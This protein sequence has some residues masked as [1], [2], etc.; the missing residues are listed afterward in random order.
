MVVALANFL[1]AAP[2]V[3]V[4]VREGR[5]V[6][7][8][9][10][11]P[12][13]DKYMLVI[14]ALTP[15]LGPHAVAVRTQAVR[16]EPSVPE[17]AEA[18]SAAWLAEAREQRRRIE[19]AR[20]GGELADEF[21]TSASPP[22]ERVFHLFIKDQEFT[23]PAAYV[24]V[25]GELAA[26]GKHVQVY[27]DREHPDPAALRPTVDDLIRTFDETVYPRARRGLGRVL[28]VDRDGRFTVLLTDRLG[29]LVNGRVSIS[30]FVRGS[31]F[32]RDMPA[33]FS[34]HCDMMYL[35]ADLKPGP[36]L[37]TVLAH[38]YTHAVIFSE[39]VFGRG[40]LGL[41]PRDEETWLNEAL[42]HVVEKERGFGWTNLDYR[43]SAFLNAPERYGVVIED[44][45]GAGLWRSHGHRGATF[46][47]LDACVA[48][49]SLPLVARLVQSPLCGVRNLEVAAE[50]PFP[51]LFRDWT[52]RLAFAAT[53]E[54]C[55]TQGERWLCGPHFHIMTMRGANERLTLAGTSAAFVLLHSPTAEATRVTVQAAADVGLQVTLLHL[56]PHSARLEL[57]TDESAGKVRLT[58][59]AHDADVRLA[60]AAWERL[61]PVANQPGDTSAHSEREAAQCCRTWFGE[62]LLKAGETRTSA[63]IERP[64]CMK[65]EAWLFKVSGVD[66]TGACIRAW[67]VVGE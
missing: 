14:G 56:P 28:D 46:L 16:E 5:C 31:D 55:G 23:D 41:A 58:L 49:A 12:A 27:V 13:G 48:N 53:R 21:P 9:P 35:N 60:G 43:V 25:T 3:P 42:A 40:S 2:P 52:S 64:D 65:K 17:E 1:T 20:A 44:Y 7:T 4:A 36:H 6:F 61:V 11:G 54:P 32:Y 24:A 63:T 47:F 50:R 57:T 62:E 15:K 66:T 26:L 37:R 18:I 29:R 34:N 51:L 59:R 39:H 45:Y 10:A 67:A 38:E 30:G 33:P 19:A 8:L 22:R